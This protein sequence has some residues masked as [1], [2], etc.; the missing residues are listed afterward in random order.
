MH[1]NI[2]ALGNGFNNNTLL[3]HNLLKI[4]NLIF[5]HVVNILN[6]RSVVSCFKEAMERKLGLTWWVGLVVDK[7]VLGNDEEVGS[8]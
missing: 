3:F 5:V 7:E 2:V 1:F 6:H 4:T 8:R